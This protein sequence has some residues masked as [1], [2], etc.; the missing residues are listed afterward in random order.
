MMKTKIIA[1]VGQSGCGKTTLVEHLKQVCAIPTVVSHTTRPMRIG[2]TN[3]VEHWFV[4]KCNTPQKDMLA[5]TKFGGYEYWAETSVAL[6]HD[7]CTYVVDE[8]G[9]ARLI[10]EH[11][12]KFLITPIYIASSD[13]ELA[14]RVGVERRTRDVN[15]L[16]IDPN[17]YSAVIVNNGTLE[18]FLE[19]AVTLL[20]ETN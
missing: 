10:E 1:I 11:D 3:G 16:V 4:G 5:H 20:S 13:E 8:I 9:L 17:V 18:E 7:V 2:E 19:A 15:R 6:Q 14:K 12:D